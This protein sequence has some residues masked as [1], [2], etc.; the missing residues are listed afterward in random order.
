MSNSQRGTPIRTSQLVSD[1]L[2]QMNSG[3]TQ[4]TAPTLCSFL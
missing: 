3:T 4:C 2:Q 1:G